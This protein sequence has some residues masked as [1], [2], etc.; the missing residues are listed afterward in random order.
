MLNHITRFQ[1]NLGKGLYQRVNLLNRACRF[2][3]CGCYLSL[4]NLAL[5]SKKPVLV[6][7]TK[8]SHN[9]VRHNSYEHQPPSEKFPTLMDFPKLMYPS[10]FKTIKNYVTVILIIK[11]YFDIDFNLDDFIV[12]SKQAVEV[13]KI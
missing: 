8:I 6:S 2:S 13:C 4:N 11:P 3:T 5:T 12:G 7:P 9:Y 10:F 1:L